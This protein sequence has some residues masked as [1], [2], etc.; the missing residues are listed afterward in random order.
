MNVS[1]TAPVLGKDEHSA[2]GGEN[3]G[4]LQEISKLRNLF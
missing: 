2:G 1:Q 3:F 4:I